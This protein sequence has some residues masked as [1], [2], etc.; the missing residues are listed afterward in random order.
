MA[1]SVADLVLLDSVIT[2]D[3]SPV[4]PVPL[5]GL[6]FG[7][8]RGYYWADLDAEVERVANQALS[9]LMDAGV[10]LV[11]VDLAPLPADAFK[12]R[13]CRSIQLFEMRPDLTRYLAAQDGAP[14]FSDVAAAIGSP[15]VKAGLERLV[16]GPDAPSP[17]MYEQA[18]HQ[19]RPSLQAAFAETF[20]GKQLDATL[21]PMTQVPALPIGQ[22]TEFEVKGD[23][24]SIPYLGRNA[25]PG[26][27]A[28]LP[29]ICLPC[30]LT[31]SNLPV[32]M[33]LDAPAGADRRLLGIGMSVEH[34]LGRIPAPAL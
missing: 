20:K 25:D 2:G 24:F 16:L 22:D 10:E 5:K 32:G 13:R 15:P 12:T 18:M 3:A 30:G 27:C 29:G 33:A 9:K 7:V 1:R 8:A 23:K 4:E 34:A 28:G 31:A 11:E 6:R 19:Y 26:A 21:F 17:E 14:S